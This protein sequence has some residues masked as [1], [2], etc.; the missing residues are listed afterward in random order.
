MGVHL[1]R[2]SAMLLNSLRAI[3]LLLAVFNAFG[4]TQAAYVYTFSGRIPSN[5]HPSTGTHPSIAPGETWVATFIIDETTPKQS[6]GSTEGDYPG[7][8]VS[9]ELKF[10]GGYVSPLNFAGFGVGVNNSPVIDSIH[11]YGF[12]VRT[13]SIVFQAVSDR[14]PL[15]SANLPVPGTNVFPNPSVA[16]ANFGYTQLLYADLYGGISYFTNVGYNVSFAATLVPEPASLAVAS[17]LGGS[18]VLAR[19]RRS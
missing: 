11:V 8:V 7:A 18:L 10:S 17:L 6:L 1:A 19:R 15:G 2:I 9:G 5:I 4:T 16:V 14:N 12:G 3:V 13:G